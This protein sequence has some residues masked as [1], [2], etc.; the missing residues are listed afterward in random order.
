MTHLTDYQEIIRELS[1]RIVAAQKPI[2]ILDALKWDQATQRQFFKDKCKKLP[3][4]NT[5]FYQ[6]KNPLQFNPRKKIEEF[7]DIE[8]SIRRK[9]GQY[10]GVGSIMQRMCREYTQVI[11]MLMA[12]GSKA[13]TEISQELY[14][15][16]EDAFHVGAPT[17]KDLA[18]LVTK[19]LSNIKEQVTTGDDIKKYSSEETVQILIKRFSR[20]FTDKNHVPRVELSDGI[21]ADAAAGADRIKIHKGSFFSEREIRVF[22][23]HEGWV[24]LGTTLN[25]L[26][27]PVCTFLSKGPPSSTITQEGLA[28][29]TEI[30]TFASYPGRLKR[31]TNRITAVNMAE[32]GANFLEVFHFYCEQGLEKE[33]AYHAALRVFR[34]SAPD[35]GPFTKDL[36]YS[37]GFILIYNY[38]RLA[39]QRGLVMQIPL[40][41]VGKTTLS[42]VHILADLV[43]E[44]IMAPPRY[45]PSQFQDIAALSAWMCY[46]LFL[47]KL[48]LQRLAM[49][50]KAILL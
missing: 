31:L 16:S 43:D 47:N 19:T 15:S 23:V 29:I 9:L 3:A 40:L 36:S 37:K 33:D 50:F 7:H 8:R 32:E 24:H 39:V 4:I 44:G 34:G 5:E 38:I 17:L 30:F 20:Y 45:I 25:G 27:Q 1:D 10:S 11:D 14:G 21:L 2:R 46:S 18:A 42:D 12:R 13:F 49:D 48:D 26:A 28:I 41:F 22:E 35:S 6:Q